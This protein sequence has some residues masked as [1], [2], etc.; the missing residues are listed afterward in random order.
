LK[1]AVLVFKAEDFVEEAPTPPATVT[2]QTGTADTSN[3][4]PSLVV[5]WKPTVGSV[6]GVD[7]VE[8]V[9]QDGLLRFEW[10]PGA[11]EIAISLAVSQVTKDAFEACDTSTG[12]I[13]TWSPRTVDGTSMAHI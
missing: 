3:Q 1:I 2:K 7:H 10:R 4:E 5:D 12:V 11:N 8:T 6:N 13:R 9:T